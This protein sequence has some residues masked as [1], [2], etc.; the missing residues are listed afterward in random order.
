[1]FLETRSKKTD[2]RNTD[3]RIHLLID[4][5]DLSTRGRYEVHQSGFTQ[6]VRYRS[7]QEVEQISALIT[8]KEKELR[9]LMRNCPD[10]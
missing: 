1:M 4:L 2:A 7:D 3:R 5:V 10:A 8:K 9:V 6:T